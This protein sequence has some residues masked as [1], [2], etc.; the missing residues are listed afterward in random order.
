[1]RKIRNNPNQ[2]TKFYCFF[3]FVY[4]V[5]K[6][7]SESKNSLHSRSASKTHSPKF[8]FIPVDKI[9]LDP[10]HEMRPLCNCCH[11]EYFPYVMWYRVVWYGYTNISMDT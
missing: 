8:T 11:K 6:S 7:I 4:F 5:F 10:L 9:G 3:F 1:M 2:K